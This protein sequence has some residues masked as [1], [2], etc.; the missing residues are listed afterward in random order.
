[1]AR[2]PRRFG[3]GAAGGSSCRSASGSCIW[4][5]MGKGRGAMCVGAGG[6]ASSYARR[7]QT[8]TKAEAGPNLVSFKDIM[9]MCV[10]TRIMTHTL[11]AQRSN[12]NPTPQSIATARLRRASSQPR[13]QLAV[14]QHAL[15]QIARHLGLRAADAKL[16]QRQLV[17][18]HRAADEGRP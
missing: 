10:T 4:C 14:R 12:D 5:A 6:T 13:L 7:L 11:G 3:N 17:R 1:V 16:P 2:V 9:V 8:R 18:V 15:E